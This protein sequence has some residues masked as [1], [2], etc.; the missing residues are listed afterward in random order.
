MRMVTCILCGRSCFV[1]ISMK[2]VK[3]TTRISTK[4]WLLHCPNPHHNKYHLATNSTR[5]HQK[6]TKRSS[7]VAKNV[8]IEDMDCISVENRADERRTA[9][10]VQACLSIPSHTQITHRATSFWPKATERNANHFS[11]IYSIQ[12]KWYLPPCCRCGKMSP[13]CQRTVRP[14]QLRPGWS[15]LEMMP[16]NIFSYTCCNMSKLRHKQIIKITCWEF[17]MTRINSWFYPKVA[18]APRRLKQRSS[19][20]DPEKTGH[21]RRTWVIA[22]PA[23]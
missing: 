4:L 17:T 1:C 5:P 2:N 16:A 8:M 14:L 15:D 6:V 22:G 12:G 7:W 11:V 18:C 10:L 21:D 9:H 3:N 13:L 20:F 19:I 23:S